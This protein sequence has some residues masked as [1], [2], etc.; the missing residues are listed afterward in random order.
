MVQQC[1]LY[2]LADAQRH[3]GVAIHLASLVINH[4][5]LV[6]TASYDNLPEFTRRFIVT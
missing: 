1:W 4:E 6:V 3:T 2:A 5:H